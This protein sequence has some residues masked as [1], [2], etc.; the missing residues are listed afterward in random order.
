MFYLDSNNN[1]YYIG[2][3]F[4]Y[5]DYQYNHSAATHAKFTELGFTQVI[6]GARPDDQFYIVSGPDLTGAYTSTPR[7]LIELK[8]RFVRKTKLASRQ[9]LS[10]TDWLVIR[11]EENGNI[12]PAEV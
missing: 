7:D 3:A 6:I 10:K 5:G 4:S 8:E 9:L 2:R 12:I 1:K 11:K